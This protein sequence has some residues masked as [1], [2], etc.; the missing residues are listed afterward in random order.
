MEFPVTKPEDC[1]FR[2]MDGE[3]GTYE[4][5]LAKDGS[6]DVCDQ[7]T[8]HRIEGTPREPVAG[9]VVLPYRNEL[10]FTLPSDCVCGRGKPFVV[11]VSEG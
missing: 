7:G 2:Y 11:C 9:V 5:S 6:G 4:C 10:V 8:Y 3:Y 1:P